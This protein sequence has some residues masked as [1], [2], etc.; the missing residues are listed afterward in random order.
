MTP[1]PKAYDLIKR[2]EGCKLEAYPDPGTGGDPITC[3][4]GHTGPEVKLGMKFSQDI[5]EAFLVKDVEHA[6]DIVRRNVTVPLTQGQFDCCIS[7]VFNIGPG[8]ESRDG[9]FRLKNGNPSTF[10]RKLNAGD[11]LGASQAMLAWN[12]SGGRVMQGLI[13]RRAAEQSLFLS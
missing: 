4:Y 11:Y 10:L 9:I 2:F 13:N 8:S 6:A 5:C 12:R 1:S 7:L 3:C